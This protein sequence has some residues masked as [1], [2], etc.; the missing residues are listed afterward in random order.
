M[1]RELYENQQRIEIKDKFTLI[2]QEETVLMLTGCLVLL[3]EHKSHVSFRIYDP[4][5]P[6]THIHSYAY[7]SGP[8]V[9]FPNKRVD[10]Y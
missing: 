8:K 9:G 2:N 6:H 7:T 5:L 3:I 10:Q 1:T 4:N